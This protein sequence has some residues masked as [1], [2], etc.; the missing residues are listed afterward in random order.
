VI[1]GSLV[2]GP[3]TSSGRWSVWCWSRSRR[4]QARGSMPSRR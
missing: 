1:I 4:W 3:F 2:A